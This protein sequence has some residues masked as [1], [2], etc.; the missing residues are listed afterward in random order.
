MDN[1]RALITGVTGFVGSHLARALIRESWEVHAVARRHSDLEQLGDIRD[2]LQVHSLDENVAGAVKI[3]EKSQPDVVF[4]LASQFIAEHKPEEIE[5]LIVSNVL[6]GTHLIEAMALRG[7]KYLV[8]T[9][10]AWQHFENRDYDP[11]NLYAATKE[12]FQAILSFY[13]S[14]RDLKVITLK[15]F[16][17]YGP[18]DRRPKIFALLRKMMNQK[19]PVAMSPGDQRLD[20]TYI[21]DVVDA[22]LVAAARLLEGRVSGHE[23]YAVSSGRTVSLRELVATFQRETKS[24]VPVQWGGRPYRKREVMVPWNRGEPLPGW[25]PRVP[26]AE[27]IKRL[28][29]WEGWAP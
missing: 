15:L 23:R 3:V 29:V 14:V 24:I 20:L 21:D 6:F 18:D 5:N 7:V 9:G 2:R 28:M 8:N 26:L 1:R 4:H 13:I 25:R 12:A 11:V 19:E 22:Y 16:D 10:T 17:T 27:G